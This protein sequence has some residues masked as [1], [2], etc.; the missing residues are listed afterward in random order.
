LKIHFRPFFLLKRRGFSQI[1]KSKHPTLFLSHSLK[2]LKIQPQTATAAAA[3]TNANDV[4]KQQ[5][6]RLFYSLS[7]RSISGLL[8]RYRPRFLFC[9]SLCIFGFLNRSEELGIWRQRQYFRRCGG[10]DRL[11]WRRSWRRWT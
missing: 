1:K 11:R 10:G 8:Q 5:L 4:N 6:W 3:T 7:V 2:A 9:R